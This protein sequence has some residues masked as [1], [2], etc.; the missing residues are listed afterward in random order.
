MSRIDTQPL[1]DEA[2]DQNQSQKTKVNY[3]KEFL[4]GLTV[5]F[6][7]LSLGAA[8]GDQCGRGALMGVLSAGLLALITSLVGGTMVQ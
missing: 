7:A 8:F 5:S 1:Q 6:A 2:A 3:S 4:A